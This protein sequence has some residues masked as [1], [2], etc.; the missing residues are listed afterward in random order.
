MRMNAERWLLA[1]ALAAALVAI[2]LALRSQTIHSTRMGGNAYATN[3]DLSSVSATGAETSSPFIDAAYFK[4]AEL[5]LTWS[6]ITGSPS[7]C[8]IQVLASADGVS[9]IDSGSAVTVTPGTSSVSVFTGA[10]GS[11]VE[12]TYSCTTYPTAGTLTLES[13]Y[14]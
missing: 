14:K 8:K 11:Q 4:Q 1:L 5:Y 9:F 12:Y 2:P 13:V 7:G 6:G 3:A 10:L